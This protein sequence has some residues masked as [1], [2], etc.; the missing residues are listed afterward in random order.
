MEGT[1]CEETGCLVRDFLPFNCS[2]CEKCYCLEHRSRFHHSCVIVN[3]SRARLQIQN[4]K[5]ESLKDLFDNVSKRFDIS[6]DFNDFG[7]EKTHLNIKTAVTSIDPTTQRVND[8]ILKL[9]DSNA[10]TLK[11]KFI[12]K[13]TREILIA[14][15]AIGTSFHR[16]FPKFTIPLSSISNVGIYSNRKRIDRS[17]R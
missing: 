1:C 4:M 16:Y 10:S 9:S 13:K 5:E 3:P 8:K 14:K 6:A 15:N 2:L 12:N 17:I 11:Q 7:T